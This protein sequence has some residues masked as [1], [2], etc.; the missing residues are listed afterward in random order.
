MSGCD[1]QKKSFKVF[2]NCKVTQE[3][4]NRIFRKKKINIVCKECGKIMDYKGNICLT[5]RKQREIEVNKNL[6]EN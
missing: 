1:W 6:W 2:V 4:W 3:E 5:C